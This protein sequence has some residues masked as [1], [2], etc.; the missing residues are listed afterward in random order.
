MASFLMQFYEGVPPPKLILVDREPAEC[1]LVAEALGEAAGCKVEIGVPQRGNRRRLLEQAWRNA[2]EELDRRLAE[3]S[4]QAKLGRE[5]AELFDLD[6]A[7]QR[8]EI[9]DNS[10]I[11]GTNA[12]GAM[13]VAG[14]EGWIKGAYRKFNIKR[15]ETRPGDDFAMMREVFQ[16]RF[17]PAIEEDPERTRG[18][19]PNLVLLDCGNGPVREV[20]AV[21]ADRG[22]RP[23]PP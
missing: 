21:L 10:H 14:S 5:L 11:Q 22:P 2:G 3:S 7:P 8:I 13:V 15:A 6:E 18:E 12:L 23:I 9:Y 4:S 16:R 17:A 19:R 20:P 1:A